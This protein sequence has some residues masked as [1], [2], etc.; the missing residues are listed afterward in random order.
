MILR[1]IVFGEP[2][3]GGAQ[4]A[5]ILSGLSESVSYCNRSGPRQHDRVTDLPFS[6]PQIGL[7]LEH[8][9]ELQFVDAAPPPNDKYG[10]F[11][12]HHMPL[13]HQGVLAA[14]TDPL[15]LECARLCNAI[16]AYPGD[17]SEPWDERLTSAGVEWGLRIDGKRGFV[18]FRGS[19]SFLDWLRDITVI[20]PS[21]MLSR[22]P[23]GDMWDGFVIGV[24]AAWVAIKPLLVGLDEVIFTG[25]S[26]GAAHADVAAAYALH[27]TIVVQIK[28]DRHG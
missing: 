8:P 13:Y 17:P 3:P 7:D 6:I 18:V 28:G 16:Y 5:K 21:R 20:D 14:K 10:I 4:F 1:R 9:T 26:L 12:W 27:Q 19:V 22:E 11:S 15:H 2:H 25:H 24:A 23:F